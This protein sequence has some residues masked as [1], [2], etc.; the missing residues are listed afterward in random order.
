MCAML[1]TKDSSTDAK[2]TNV[3][4]NEDSIVN[5]CTVLKNGKV[6]FSENNDLWWMNLR[7]YRTLQYP[8]YVNNRVC[9]THT[10]DCVGFVVIPFAKHVRGREEKVEKVTECLIPRQHTEWGGTKVRYVVCS[11][12]CNC[13]S[14]FTHFP[15]HRVCYCCIIATPYSLASSPITSS[16]LHACFLFTSPRV[17]CITQGA[18]HLQ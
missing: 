11:Y 5:E 6:C 15:F 3:Q 17:L 16:S 14:L 8:E 13:I 4:E 1:C 10:R 2:H 7:Q 9:N 18:T 12:L